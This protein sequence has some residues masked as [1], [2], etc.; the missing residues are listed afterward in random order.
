[1]IKLQFYDY[2]NRQL[3]IEKELGISSDVLDFLLENVPNIIFEATDNEADLEDNW[4]FWF[5]SSQELQ[6]VFDIR[7]ILAMKIDENSSMKY[8]IKID[9]M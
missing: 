1:M 3:D 4:I 8:D 6:A 5:S 7:E 9:K 2:G